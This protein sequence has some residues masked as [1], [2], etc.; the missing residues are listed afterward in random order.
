[1]RRSLIALIVFLWVAGCGEL[2]ESPTD[3]GDIDPIDQSATFARVRAEILP[4][5]TTIGCHDS[6]GQ[7]EGLVLEPDVAYGNLVNH[8]SS[9]LPQLNRVEP[10]DPDASYMY[11]KITGRQGIIGDRM[12]LFSTPLG[13]A[14]INLVRNW[15]RRGAP[16]D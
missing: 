6:I 14:E 13:E 15:I 5:C 2:G 7:S 4:K 11:W 10:G 9:E 8:A 12:P 3:P 1:M 16:N